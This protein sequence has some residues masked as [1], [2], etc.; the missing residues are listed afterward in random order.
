VRLTLRNAKNP[1]LKIVK[2]LPGPNIPS[3]NFWVHYLDIF[4]VYVSDESNNVTDR[5]A[6]HPTSIDKVSVLKLRQGGDPVSYLNF[7]RGTKLVVIIAGKI[8]FSF[9]L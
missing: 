9:V 3:S 1:T 4:G 8:E 6:F 5:L 7:I 2:I